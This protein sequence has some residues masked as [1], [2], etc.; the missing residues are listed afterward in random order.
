MI[1]ES[2]F[3]IASCEL[4]AFEKL[5]QLYPTLIKDRSYVSYDSEAL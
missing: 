2:G 1:N 4:D 3:L 5:I